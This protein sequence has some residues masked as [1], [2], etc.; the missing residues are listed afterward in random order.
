ML[1]GTGVGSQRVAM[2][3]ERRVVLGPAVGAIQACTL[4]L[5]RGFALDLV[6]RGIIGGLSRGNV[7]FGCRCL[8]SCC[9]EEILEVVG[10]PRGDVFPFLSVLRVG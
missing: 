7:V 8:A 5:Q 6:I 9:V 3:D 4:P 2:F 1:V 10:Y